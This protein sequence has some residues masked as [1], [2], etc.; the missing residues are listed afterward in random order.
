MELFG[1]RNFVFLMAI[2]LL[3]MMVSSV[4]AIDANDEGVIDDGL[5]VGTLST[6]D[7]SVSQ[8]IVADPADDLDMYSDDAGEKLSSEVIND[9]DDSGSDLDNAEEKLSMENTVDDSSKSVLKASS[10]GDDILKADVTVYVGGP[11]GY[12]T[13]QA[14]INSLESRTDHYTIIIR[15]GTYTGYGNHEVDVR[16]NS[17]SYPN[18]AYLMIRAEEGAEVVFDG[19]N[20]YTLWNILS[21]NVHIEGIQFVNAKPRGNYSG[22]CLSIDADHFSAENCNFTNNGNKYPWGGAIHVTTTSNDLNFTNCYFENNTANVGGVIRAEKRAHDIYFKDC[23]FINNE[24]AS[25][26]GV[27]CLFGHYVGFDNCYFENNSAPSSGALHFHNDDSYVNNCTFIG[28]KT[29]GGGIERTNGYGGA[30]GLVYTTDNGVSINNSKFYNN[31]AVVD[32]G[33]VQ[34]IGGGSNAEIFNSEFD[35]NVAEYG[36]AVSIVGSNTDIE[37]VTFINNN[38]T[39]FG[40]AAYIIGSN[41]H[42]VNSKFDSNNAI[43]DEEQ[44]DKGLGGAVYMAGANGHVT[45]CNFTYNTARNGSAI[46][47]NHSSYYAE[48]Y[49]DGCDFDENQAWS[50]WLPIYYNNVTET[51]D[52]NLTGGNNILNAIYNNGSNR[53]IYID[54]DNPVLGWENSKNGTIMYQDVREVNQTIVTLVYDRQGNLV[55]NETKITNISGSVHYDLGEDTINW[56]IVNMTHLEDTYYKEITNITAINIHPGLDISDVIMYEGNSSPQTMYIV[57]SDES[58]KLLPKHGPVYIYV[59]VDGNKIPLGA[60]MTDMNSMIIFNESTIF[61][62]LK[63]G[64]Y[65]TGANYTYQ[66]YNSTTHKFVNKTI[67]GEG[68]LEVLPYAW[69][70]TKT[71]IEVN[72]EVYTEGMTIKLND[73]L[74]FNITVSNGMDIPYSS[75]KIIDANTD[76]LE[77]QETVGSEWTYNGDNSWSLSELAANTNS[78]LIVK[79]K[80]TKVGE[81]INVAN[82]SILDGLQNKSANVSFKVGAI[83]LEITKNAD[84][85]EVSVGDEV[86]FTIIVRNSGDCDATN[87]VITDVLNEAFNYESG[88]DSYDEATRTVTWNIETIKAGESASVVV[89]VTVKYVSEFNNTAVIICDENK[90]ETNDTV[91]ITVNPAPSAVSANDVTE[92][93]GEEINVKVSSE[94]ATEVEYKVIDKDGNVVAE[95]TVDANGTFT[96]NDLDVGEYTV[97][98]TTVVDDNHESITNSSK[99]T[100]TPAGS[101]VSAED[102]TIHVGEPAV[103]KPSSENATGVKYTITDKD[104]QVVT[105]GQVAAGEDITVDGLEAGEY[106]VNLETLVD[107]NHKASE[108]TSSITVKKL[109]INI[110]VNN[111]VTTPGTEVTVEIT[112]TDEN[113]DPVTCQLTVEISDPQSTDSLPPHAVSAN[114]LGSTTTTVDVDNGKGSLTYSVPEDAEDGTTYV[115]NAKAEETPKYEAGEGTGYIDVKKYKTT[116]TV[117]N[118][119]GE[120]GQEVTLKVKVTTEDGTP[121]NGDVVVQ[122]PDGTNKTVT[123]TDGKGEFTWTIPKDAENGTTYEF[124]AIFDGNSTYY[125]SNGTGIVDIVTKDNQTDNKTN[126]TNDTPVDPVDP[127]EPDNTPK[128]VTPEKAVPAMAKTGSPVVAV[129]IAFIFLGL[130][131]KRKEDD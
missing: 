87:A 127:V 2:F 50:Y 54:G 62:T 93:Y 101:S 107:D 100:V 49:I 102:V 16:R 94:N 52:T 78:S 29:T 122:C 65:T 4:S 58:G 17:S 55:F 90:T 22:V 57:L 99:I 91:P 105:R 56:F 20:T 131:L 67:T 59:E 84:P 125:A 30:V 26:G 14:A 51:I 8:E 11:G 104:G 114:G 24:A 27:A 111:Y 23:T 5:A 21:N 124:T 25:H 9:S 60:F 36:G 112:V 31:T 74:T 64:T 1:K 35:N 82:A 46:Y 12:S 38:A 119:T 98:L 128:E 53:R 43:P 42:I 75:V 129:L 106:T 3:L 48:N 83:N 110:V 70:L 73:I 97:N 47:V 69:N 34:I 115:V 72:G 71:I 39:L 40:G 37:N 108:S 77:Y 92:V 88:G 45:D 121:F 130:G 86:I 7:A 118:A 103:I 109:N 32:G 81:S 13:L 96:V 117:S 89:Y 10:E 15:E 44:I 63:A 113:G 85:A 41:T 76:G 116:T 79:F 19:Q 95:G 123:V 28:N 120:P 80:A 33:A 126:D 61:K 6:S 18:F 66:Y 68:K